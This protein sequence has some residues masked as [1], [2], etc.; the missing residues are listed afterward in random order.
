MEGTIGAITIF[1]ADFEPKYFAFCSGQI[2]Q[3][4]QN[5]ALFSILGTTYG[6]NGVQTF[7]LPDLRSRC[8]VSQGQGNGLSNYTLGEMTGFESV[9]LNANNLPSHVHNGAMQVHLQAFGTDGD[10]QSPDAAY[11]AGNPGGYSNTAGAG[12]TMQPPVYTGT[13]IG[14]AGSSSP[15]NLLSPYLAINYVICMY[16]IYPSRN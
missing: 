1:A 10:S 8:P 7:A 9:L 4:S 12:Q 14:P 3:I 2:I 6:G 11:P 5:T 15:I 16:G 13:T